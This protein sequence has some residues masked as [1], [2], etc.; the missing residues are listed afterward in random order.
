MKLS[1]D[2]DEL[3]S[4]YDVVV[5]GS[6]YGASVLAT[7]LQ[8]RASRG[9]MD[10]K[11][12]VCVLERG[13]EIES[14]A[15]PSELPALRNDTQLDILGDHVGTRLGLFDFHINR[16]VD[17]LVGC[18]LGG[19]SLINGSIS[20]EPDPRVF[21]EDC[22]PEA[23]RKDRDN[24]SLA[25]YYK[26]A[27]SVL[28]PAQYPVSQPTPA[29]LQALEQA[30]IK[31]GGPFSRCFVNLHFDEAGTN[32][33]G[34]YQEP[35]IS[36]GDCVT[37]CNFKAKNT[38][39]FTYLPLAKSF[40]AHIFVQ[41]DVRYVTKEEGCYVVHF[42]H[43]TTGQEAVRIDGRVRAKAVV[44]GAGVLG[45]TAILLRSAGPGLEFSSRLG[46]RFSSNGDAVT[47]GYNCDPEVDT[48]GFGHDALPPKSERRPNRPT[49]ATLLGLVDQRYPDIPVL[50][51]L[52]IE[53]GAFPS[54][55]TKLLLP[56]VQII[57]ASGKETG[58]GLVRW[59]RERE[60]EGLDLLNDME[61]GALNHT[62]LYFTMGHDGSNGR[63]SLD[64]K[65]NAQITWPDLAKAPY[66]EVADGRVRK[67]TESLGGMHVRNPLWSN[68][69]G[70][71]LITVHPLGG[72][73]MG[74]DVATG[75]VDHLG[76][77]F[78]PAHADGA[79]HDRLYI[80]DGSVIPMSL[81]VNPL[82]TIT[83]LAERTA[84]NA[85]TELGYGAVAPAAQCAT[86]RSKG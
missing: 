60:R 38:I 70:K 23:I 86:A 52:I 40:G 53:E 44:V 33:S 16:D 27:R 65:G 73:A 41:C 4:D 20:I 82:L 78:D 8:E 11:P 49:G 19:T 63:I 81:G 24:R 47:F 25:Q 84:Q 55:L 48:I 59:L 79:F 17:V 72:C 6:G 10:S 74:N 54:G 5:I 13:R 50:E 61:N 37:G 32:P 22:W 34:V 76:R 1:N 2:F 3:Q 57:V 18:G 67:L 80:A 64:G 56:L 42:Q 77:V 66:F 31:N 21:D 71:N 69:F 83:A 45:S 68:T 43:I 75:V 15:F 39:P 28:R 30:A 26:L 9:G 36:C 46:E 35:C 62:M 29:K 51:G 85:A 7:R 58:T 14:G 12:R